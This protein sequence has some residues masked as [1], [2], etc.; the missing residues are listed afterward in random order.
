MWTDSVT[1]SDTYTHKTRPT[2]L[3]EQEQ[4]T[5]YEMTKALTQI[6]IKGIT[7]REHARDIKLQCLEADL[8]VTRLD[9]K[10]I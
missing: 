3:S 5:F 1:N 10:S 2:Q 7:L 4:N 9:D 8:V 6:V